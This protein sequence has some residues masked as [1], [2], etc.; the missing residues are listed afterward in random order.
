MSN[1]L[2]NSKTIKMTSNIIGKLLFVNNTSVKLTCTP[3]KKSGDQEMMSNK[4]VMEYGDNMIK[5]NY[6]IFKVIDAKKEW[7]KSFRFL[8]SQVL[9]FFGHFYKF[10]NN[11]FKKNIIYIGETGLY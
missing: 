5:Y 6:K 11:K 10:M 8:R 7:V 9:G 3:S 2:L 4:Y 1:I